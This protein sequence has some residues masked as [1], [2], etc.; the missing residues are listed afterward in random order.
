MP[1]FAE[2]LKLLTA[3]YKSVS[4]LCRQIDINRSQFARYV[5]GDSK[6]SAYNLRKIAK[7][8]G[9]PPSDICMRHKQF[10]ERFGGDR[11]DAT[12]TGIISLNPLRGASLGSIEEMKAYTGYYFSYL[13]SPTQPTGLLQSLVHLHFDGTNVLSTMDEKFSRMSDGSRQVS[14]YDGVVSLLN[15]CIFIVD[16]ETTGLDTILETILKLPHRRKSDVLVGLIMGMTTGMQRMPFASV[17]AWKFLGKRIDRSSKL[18]QCGFHDMNAASID[19]S[20]REAFL[21]QDV[22]FIYPRILA[23]P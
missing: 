15:G 10:A 19:P 3:R 6:P 4:E 12:S 1:D 9:I 2:N 13:Q 21:Q 17:T 23:R 7:H 5:S 22:R 16:I 20:V 18:K 8:F 14:R 11:K